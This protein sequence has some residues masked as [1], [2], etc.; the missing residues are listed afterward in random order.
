MQKAVALLDIPVVDIRADRS[1]LLRTSRDSIDIQ[2]GIHIDN[3]HRA[4]AEEEEENL[5]VVEEEEEAKDLLAVY[6]LP[7]KVLS[8]IVAIRVSISR[9]LL[10]PIRRG[11]FGHEVANDRIFVTHEQLKLYDDS[12]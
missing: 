1:P 11:R 5:V 12:L 4:F 6:H 9:R 10:C 8:G 7:E 2:V 3:I